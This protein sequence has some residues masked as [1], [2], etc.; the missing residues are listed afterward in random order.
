MPNIENEYFAGKPV[1]FQNH[2]A[3]VV[4][5]Q[6]NTASK[7]ITIKLKNN[8]MPSIVSTDDIAPEEDKNEIQYTVAELK[9]MQKMGRL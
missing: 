5:N 8:A 1:K 6:T 7:K 4:E 3:Y 9:V 2:E